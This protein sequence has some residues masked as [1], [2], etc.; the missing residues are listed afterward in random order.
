M[1]LTR[2]LLFEPFKPGTWLQIGFCA[3]LMSL[4]D[5]GIGSGFSFN[6]EWGMP[7]LGTDPRPGLESREMAEM[8]QRALVWLGD[9]LLLVVGIGLVVLT[10]ITVFSLVLLWLG[11]RGRFMFLNGVV[12][13]RF[14]I[15]KAWHTYR[16]EGNSLFWFR[17]WFGAVCVAIVLTILLVS[18]L[19]A[20]P[21]LQAWRF[22]P[23]SVL[24]IAVGMISALLVVLVTLL[25]QTALFDFVVPIMFLRHIPAL[26][27]WG[28][29]RRSFLAPEPMALLFYVVMMV[30]LGI[31][32]GILSL[33]V[34]VFSCCIAL[35]PYVGSVILLPFSVFMQ[36]WTILF[37]E[38]FGPDW[39]F[40][41]RPENTPG[42]VLGAQP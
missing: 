33:L 6:D 13:N 19:I 9:H 18:L 17:F 26:A 40:P 29:F 22:G 24:A 37:I 36:A 7:G 38:Q 16:K 14:T 31:A 32:I 25:V 35:L 4:A 28:H 1:A 21:D 5:G 11:S 3:F 39:Q 30:L 10:V 23:A 41:A 12:A 42:N 8:L 20:L 27:A 15:D 2:R 34:I